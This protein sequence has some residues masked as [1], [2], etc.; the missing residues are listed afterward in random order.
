[1]EAY[2]TDQESLEDRN[3]NKQRKRI[4]RMNSFV[5]DIELID[6]ETVSTYIAL[7][8]D[9]KEPFKFLMTPEDYSEFFKKVPLKTGIAMKQITFGNQ[10]DLVVKI[11]L[12]QLEFIEKVFFPQ[13]T[14]IKK[15]D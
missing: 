4:D 12:D 7:D 15:I 10:K 1:M 11:M 2:M 8:G 9:V 5:V 14:E 6:K 3:A 13:E